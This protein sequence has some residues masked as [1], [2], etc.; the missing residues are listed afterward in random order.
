MCSLLSV[1][2]GSKS[3]DMSIES[4]VTTETRKMKGNHLAGGIASASDFKGEIGKGEHRSFNFT[5]R[6]EMHTEG[7]KV[8]K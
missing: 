5:E 1:V 7:E 6:K 2:P 4:V 3:S 8:I